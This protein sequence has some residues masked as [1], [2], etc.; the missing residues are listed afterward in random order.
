[1][2]L[3]RIEKYC[4]IYYMSKMDDMYTLILKLAVSSGDSINKLIVRIICIKLT[5]VPIFKHIIDWRG[6]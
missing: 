6:R 4:R 3:N 2:V 1:M 5:R